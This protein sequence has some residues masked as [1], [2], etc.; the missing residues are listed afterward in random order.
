MG[1]STERRCILEKYLSIGELS[2]L[3]SVSIKSLRYYDKIGILKPAYINP[4]TGYRYYSQDQLI[5]LDI[6]FMCLELGIPLKDLKDYESP[7]GRF[8]LK[9]LLDDG[10]RLA[11]NKINH[12]KNMITKLESL[13]NEME[14]FQRVKG[15]KESY[16][17]RFGERYFLISPFEGDTEDEYNYAKVFNGLYLKGMELGVNLLY[18]QG[19]VLKY[20]GESVKKY[21]FI[22]ISSPAEVS[23][24][25]FILPGGEYECTLLHSDV[26]LEEWESLGCIGTSSEDSFIVVS[27]VLDSHLDRHSYFREKQVFIA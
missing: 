23:E 14:S 17:R 10:S 2:K 13:T 12:I 9:K 11:Y 20:S 26:F 7:E 5:N 6:I 19:W 27:E 22:E 25:I 15:L 21:S 1:E 4:E 3:K 24:D 18:N 8:N 16:K